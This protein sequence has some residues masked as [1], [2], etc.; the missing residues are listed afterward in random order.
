VQD[1]KLPD[2]DDLDGLER[3]VVPAVENIIADCEPLSGEWAAWT[4]LLATIRNRLL[5]IHRIEQIDNRLTRLE[6]HTASLTDEGVARVVAGVREALA[7]GR[8]G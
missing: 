2:L 8:C 5:L 1:G 6:E 7:D 3:V 4:T